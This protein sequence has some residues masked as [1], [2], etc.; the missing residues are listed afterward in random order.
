[1][2]TTCV[3]GRQK[4]QVNSGS[5]NKSIFNPV[6]YVYIESIWRGIGIK[7]PDGD[8]IMNNS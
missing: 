3:Q 4:H 6:L 7:E 8:T 5:I 1:M 2:K